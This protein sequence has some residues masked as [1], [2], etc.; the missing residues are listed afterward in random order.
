MNPEYL[1]TLRTEGKPDYQVGD[2]ITLVG[3]LIV[4]PNRNDGPRAGVP[5]W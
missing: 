1:H 3:T 5:N 2:K 4:C